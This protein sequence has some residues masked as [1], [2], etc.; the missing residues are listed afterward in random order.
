MPSDT[1]WTVVLDSHRQPV[2]AIAPGGAQLAEDVVVA[3]AAVPVRD[4]LRS[5]ALAHATART[6]VVVRRGESVVGVWAGEDLLHTLLRGVTRGSSMPGDLQ[7]FGP[8]R[9][10]RHHPALSACR[11]GPHLRGGPR[12]AGKARDNAAVPGP[13][14]YCRA[15]L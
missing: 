14:R 2:A 6:V 3:N 5:E 15:C 8:Y 9:E 12:R 4:A 10:D 1:E 11:E 7:L 13:A